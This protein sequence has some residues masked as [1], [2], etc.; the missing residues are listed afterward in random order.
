MY[1]AMKRAAEKKF[2]QAKQQDEPSMMSMYA[3]DARDMFAI[4][5][6][7]KDGDVLAAY[8]KARLMDTAARDEIPTKVYRFLEESVWN[9]QH[10]VDNCRSPV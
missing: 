9:M 6:M 3:G 5:R 2:E 7:I 1:V 4:A 10:G 8:N